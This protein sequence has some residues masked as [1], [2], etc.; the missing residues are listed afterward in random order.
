MCASDHAFWLEEARAELEVSKDYNVN[1]NVAKNVII[2]LG[3]GMSIST[4]TATRIYKGQQEG[5]SGEEYKL[6]W[7]DFPDLGLIKVSKI[8]GG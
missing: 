6:S 7:E 3:D 1:T 8:R 5:M 2:F 4:I